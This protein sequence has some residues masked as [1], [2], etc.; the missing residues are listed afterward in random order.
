MDCTVNLNQSFTTRVN[1]SESLDQIVSNQKFKSRLESELFERNLEKIDEKPTTTQQEFNLQDKKH[2]DYCVRG[3][4]IDHSSQIG[5]MVEVNKIMSATFN[6]N[7]ET[8]IFARF[9][10]ISF[11]PV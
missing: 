6:F 11:S 9:D 7:L 4:R 10:F 2:I 5:K 3:E 8:H 1:V